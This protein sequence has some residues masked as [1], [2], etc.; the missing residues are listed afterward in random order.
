MRTRGIFIFIV[1]REAKDGSRLGVHDLISPILDRQLSNRNEGPN[2]GPLVVFRLIRSRHSPKSN[3]RAVSLKVE[4]SMIDGGYCIRTEDESDRDA[5]SLM[6]NS[7]II[8][9][10]IKQ[11]VN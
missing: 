5:V 10:D 1:I 4:Y 2:L 7:T 3:R 8:L 9:V 6:R 11:I